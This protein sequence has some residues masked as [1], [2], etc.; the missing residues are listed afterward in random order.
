MAMIWMRKIA[1]REEK[2]RRRDALRGDGQLLV[3]GDLLFTNFEQLLR[4]G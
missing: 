2:T 3:E 1:K 4:V